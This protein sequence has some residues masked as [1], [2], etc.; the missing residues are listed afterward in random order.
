MEGFMAGLSRHQGI[1]V[2]MPGTDLRYASL[3]EVVE[4]NK[5]VIRGMGFGGATGQLVFIDAALGWKWVPAAL[6][7]LSLN[8]TVIPIDSHRS[9]QQLAKL[10]A[11]LTPELIIDENRVSHDGRMLETQAI[12][13]PKSRAELENIAF[14]LYTSGTTGNPKGVMLSSENIWSNVHSILSYFDLSP[15][16]RML[17]IRPFTHASAITG[18]LLPCLISG[19]SVYIKP[20]EVSPLH[21]LSLLNKYK[22]SVFCATPTVCSYI[23]RVA[24][25]RSFPHL[26]KIVLSGEGLTARQLELIR[27]TFPLARIWNAYGLTEASPRVSCNTDLSDM[28]DPLCV[29]TPLPDVSIKIVDSHSRD[30]PEGEQG[31]IW[32]HGPNVMSGYCKDPENTK[33]KI[34]DGWLRTSD[35]GSFRNGKLY[36][37]GRKDELMIRGGVNIY[38]Q[39][40]EDMLLGCVGVKEAVVFAERDNGFSLKIHAWV[41][42][43][44]GIQ[45]S[46]IMTM[47]IK[48]RTDARLWPDHIEIKTELEKNH[49]GKILRPFTY[50][51]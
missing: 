28:N 51:T 41:V 22:I 9:P 26:K 44:E 32:V 40:I 12:L 15:R 19:C 4:Q 8:V 31:E 42:T 11:E 24:T 14:L 7:A 16:D 17:I 20:S 30:L 3:L 35:M 36:V 50:W 5:K 23:A 34:I 47:L 10:C 13:S 25:N 29:G 38:P 18:E 43:D 33:N 2:I 45:P 1:S 37:H 46:D 49:T 27:R 39:E 6:A 21:S 48:K